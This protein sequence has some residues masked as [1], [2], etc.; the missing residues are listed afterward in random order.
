VMSSSSLD[1]VS[2]PRKKKDRGFSF[3]GSTSNY[4]ASATDLS[5]TLIKNDYFSDMNPRSMRRLMNI[6]A[7]TGGFQ[8]TQL[9][10]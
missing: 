7:I 4:F 1:R 10:L 6:V 5:K 2:R 9:L 8:K 3:T